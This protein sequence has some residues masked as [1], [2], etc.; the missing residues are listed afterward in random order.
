MMYLVRHGEDDAAGG[1]TQNGRHA[2][3][4]LAGWLPKGTNIYSS[5]AQRARE[6]AAILASGRHYAVEGNLGEPEMGSVAPRLRRGP[7]VLGSWPCY[8]ETVSDTIIRLVNRDAD[9]VLVTHSSFLDAFF[10]SATGSMAWEFNVPPA[11]VSIFEFRGL[12]HPEGPWIVYAIGFT[13]HG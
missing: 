11:S 1:L 3:S 10:E 4:I 13:P 5:P 12:G 9:A 7:A 8:V 2:S 6:T